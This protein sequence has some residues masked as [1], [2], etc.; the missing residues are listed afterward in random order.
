MRWVLDLCG[1]V[2]MSGVVNISGI[3]KGFLLFKAWKAASWNGFAPLDMERDEFVRRWRRED[4]DYDYVCGRPLKVNIA[5]DTV[6]PW[7]FDRENGD[8]SFLRVVEGIRKDE[9][10]R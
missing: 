5:G 8:G 7:L 9:A 2:E 4:D 10:G 6:D 3:D 1:S